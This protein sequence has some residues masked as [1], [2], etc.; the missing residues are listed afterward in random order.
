M[1]LTVPRKDSAARSMYKCH[2][3]EKRDYNLIREPLTLK[4]PSTV[5]RYDKPVPCSSTHEKRNAPALSS[6]NIHTT[7]SIRRRTA[8]DW[9]SPKYFSYIQAVASAESNEADLIAQPLLNTENSFVKELDRYLLHKDVLE[10]RKK[11]LL[12]K[13][14]SKSVLEP[15]QQKVED[16]VESQSAE[17]IRSRKSMMLAK[18]LNYCN[19]KGY[20]FLE[21]YSPQEYNPCY[22][23][24]H[25]PH[26]SKVVTPAVNDP[27][28]LQ[29]RERSQVDGTILRCQTGKLYSARELEE[30]HKPK[31]PPVPHG[32]QGDSIKWIRMPLGFIESSIRQKSRQK[33]RGNFNYGTLDFEVW[34]STCY[35]PEIFDEEMQICHKRKFQKPLLFR[36]S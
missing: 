29:S 1:F 25:K 32:R 16:F 28:L 35:P 22:P 15:I 12:Y 5:T 6:R 26:Y 33:M 2:S 3:S 34:S 24:Y 20:V 11:E 10:L 19:K 17:D 36:E 7:G 14:W 27:L 31:Q 23:Q 13:K 4:Q 18:Y 8:N 30:L 21:D 9:L